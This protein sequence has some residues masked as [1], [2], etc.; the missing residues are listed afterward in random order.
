MLD[1]AVRADPHASP[2]TVKRII[3]FIVKYIV[4]RHGGQIK[5]E[6]EEGC[7]TTFQLTLP[8]TT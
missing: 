6:S 2:R 8:R 3:H 4:E 1:R 7:G 5:V